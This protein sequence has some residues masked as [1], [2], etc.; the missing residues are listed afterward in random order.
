MPGYASMPGNAGSTAVDAQLAGLVID[1][2]ALPGADESRLPPDPVERAFEADAFG[3]AEE[4]IAQ[5]ALVSALLVGFESQPSES[6]RR[7]HGTSQ[8]HT[9]IQQGP[10]DRR[11]RIPGGS[12]HQQEGE[13]RPDHFGVLTP[14]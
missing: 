10:L 13:Q 7:E 2:V 6:H 11:Q 4:V 8:S 1:P 12:R 9:S 5:E 14:H 3:H